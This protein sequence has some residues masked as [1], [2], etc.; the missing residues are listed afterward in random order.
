MRP[1]VLLADDHAMVAEAL[2]R[3]LARDVNLLATVSDGAQLVE[4][5]RLLRPDI[6]VADV[7]MPAMSAFEA[8]RQLKAEG[9]PARFIFITAHADAPM[10][11]QALLAGASGFVFKQA[12]GEDLLDAIHAAVRGETYLSPSIKRRSS[13]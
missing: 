10:A 12:A 3:L 5:A 7:N 9:L 13:A 11:A 2:G 6:I 4:R 1:S 8:M